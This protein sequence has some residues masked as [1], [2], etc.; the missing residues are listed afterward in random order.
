MVVQRYYYVLLQYVRKRI[1]QYINKEYL[2]VVLRLANS[3]SYVKSQIIVKYF[4][5]ILLVHVRIL[6]AELH[7]LYITLPIQKNAH[8]HY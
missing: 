3:I 8:V 5:G 2:I 1:L 7:F 6:F 4:K